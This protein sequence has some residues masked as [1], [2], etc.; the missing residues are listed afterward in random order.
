MESIG[1]MSGD[2]ECSFEICG[3][4]FK[5]NSVHK[6]MRCFSSKIQ[7]LRYRHGLV[8][9]WVQ[10][11]RVERVTREFSVFVKDWL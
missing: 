2:V 10:S 9:S 11:Q 8:D 6:V 5:V 7:K 1:G 3:D 4:N